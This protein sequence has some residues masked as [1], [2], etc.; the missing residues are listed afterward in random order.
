M[1]NDLTYKCVYVPLN[2]F[3]IAENYEEII[4]ID[5]FLICV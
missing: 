1:R 3:F 4:I 5:Y 2:I